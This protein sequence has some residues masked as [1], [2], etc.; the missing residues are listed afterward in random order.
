MQTEVNKFFSLGSAW[1]GTDEEMV[2]LY[3][4]TR[5]APTAFPCCSA[6][7]LVVFHCGH[8]GAGSR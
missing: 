3:P 7:F 2:Q 1:S 5:L 6:C 4:H 8:H